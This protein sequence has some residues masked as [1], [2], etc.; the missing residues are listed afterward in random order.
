[1]KVVRPLI[2]ASL[3][4]HPSVVLA[5]IAV[6]THQVEATIQPT[7]GLLS[8]VFTLPA[9]DPLRGR[10]LWV[11]IDVDCAYRFEC[12]AENFQPGPPQTPP[13]SMWTFTHSATV[14]PTVWVPGLGQIPF[15]FSDSEA[16]SLAAFDGAFDFGGASGYRILRSHKDDASVVLGEHQARTFISPIRQTGTVDIGIDTFGSFTFAAQGGNLVQFVSSNLR[17]RVVVR[18]GFAPY[19][20]YH[21]SFERATQPERVLWC[22]AADRIF[23][24]PEAEIS[25]TTAEVPM[26][27]VRVGMG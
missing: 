9:F 2:A 7:S 13:G 24:K 15:S 27:V 5:Q 8:Q 14:S 4:I 11:K 3:L 18:Y 22:L 23:T 1:M 6:Q 19:A 10:L 21:S 17:I 16:R 25:A 20:I 26:G 12:G